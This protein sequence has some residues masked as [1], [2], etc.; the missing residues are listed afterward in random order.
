MLGC[1]KLVFNHWRL[2][3]YTAIAATKAAVRQEMR[4]TAS[5]RRG[6]AKEVPFGVRALE[7]GIEVDGVWVSGTNTPRGSTSG[8]PSLVPKLGKTTQLEE[9]PRR[10]DVASSSS[11]MS[12]LDM[13]QPAH[14]YQGVPPYMPASKNTKART[15][16][17]SQSTNLITLSTDR[18]PYMPP[19]IFSEQ[20]SRG[21][22]TYQPRR[23]SGL[24]FSN[25]DNPHHAEA[26]A[27]LE[28]RPQVMIP[29]QQHST[30]EMSQFFAPVFY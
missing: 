23:S 10:S 26:M 21:R 11:S 5:V 28:G 12:H 15:G 29:T 2:R 14:G 22:E 13:L 25:A 7:S 6:R 8:S 9:Q 20:H 19:A 30:G 17:G 24:R 18:S 1:M 3:K 16:Q 4:H 27:T